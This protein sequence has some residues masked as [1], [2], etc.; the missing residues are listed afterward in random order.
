MPIIAEADRT[1]VVL[2]YGSTVS[3]ITIQSLLWDYRC[4]VCDGKLEAIATV[5]DSGIVGHVIVCPTCNAPAS[6]VKHVEAIRQ[7]KIMT[8]QV[9]SGLPDHLRAMIEKPVNQASVDEAADALYK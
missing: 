1:H 2:L 6:E 9:L 3:A 7:E 5:E 4:A 8:Q